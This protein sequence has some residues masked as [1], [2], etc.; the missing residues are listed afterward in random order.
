M[1]LLVFLFQHEGV[2]AQ[3]AGWDYVLAGISTVARSAEICI[4]GAG[5]AGRL[6]PPV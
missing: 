6:A 2:G 1:L 4:Y 3:G 5:T